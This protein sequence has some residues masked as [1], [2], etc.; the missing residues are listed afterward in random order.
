MKTKSSNYVYK[1]C[2]ICMDDVSIN[3]FKNYNCRHKWCN[4]CD[5]KLD[6]FNIETC[7]FCRKE[8][9][10]KGKW[11]LNQYSRL[12]FVWKWNHGKNETLKTRI[13]KKIQENFLNLGSSI[14]LISGRVI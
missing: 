10:D 6:K 4:I 9:N 14:A 3:N 11:E 5:K 2:N 13:I 8:L 12:L 1:K 7:P